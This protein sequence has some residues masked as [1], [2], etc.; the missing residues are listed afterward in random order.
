MD[1]DINIEKRNI[2]KSQLWIQLLF[3]HFIWLENATVYTAQHQNNATQHNKY[4][5]IHMLPTRNIRMAYIVYSS[6]HR[7]RHIA[8]NQRVA[9]RRCTIA[10]SFVYFCCSF[11]FLLCSFSYCCCAHCVERVDSIFI[12][13]FSLN[14]IFE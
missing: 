10:T 5:H 9:T 4:I 12:W 8:I 7:Q 3:I 6:S 1:T 2:R 14:P 11:F 13:Y